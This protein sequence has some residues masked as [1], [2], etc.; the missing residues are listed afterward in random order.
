MFNTVALYP[1]CVKLLRL[2]P[3]PE[4]CDT[5]LVLQ[6][7]IVFE[8]SK[9]LRRRCN[10]KI[11]LLISPWVASSPDICDRRPVWPLAMISGFSAQ[12]MSKWNERLGVTQPRV[13][14]GAYQL[15]SKE[16]LRALPPTS[17]D[18][19]NPLEALQAPLSSLMLLKKPFNSL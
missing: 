4:L 11:P 15:K 3:K 16:C 6:V 7:S 18:S 1:H 5:I 8:S 10:S 17:P 19:P 2:A 14:D 12:T 9:F 13:F